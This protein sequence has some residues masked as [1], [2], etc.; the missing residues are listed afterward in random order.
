[1]RG[2]DRRGAAGGSAHLSGPSRGRGIGERRV[3]SGRADVRRADVRAEGG[4]EDERASGRA[5]SGGER[6]A[7]RDER[8]ELCACFANIH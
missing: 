6:E 1:M 3:A 4:G 7:E 8:V 2:S 5:V